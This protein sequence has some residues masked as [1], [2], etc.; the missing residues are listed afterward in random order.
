MK[1][2]DI[3]TSATIGALFRGPSKTRW[4]DKAPS[5][6]DKKP[7]E[8]PVRILR[9]GI[10]GDQQADPRVHGGPER[11]LHHYPVQHYQTWRERFGDL[12]TLR[13]GGVGENLSVDRFDETGVCIGDS[14][15]IGTAII[16]VSQGRV[17]CWKLVRHTGVDDMATAFLDTGHTGWYARVLE[18]G[19]ARV[20]DPIELID[21]T[22]TAWSVARVIR[23][24]LDKKLDREHIEELA[25]LPGLSTHWLESFR[26]RMLA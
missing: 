5:A 16:Q 18:A 6:I 7:V 19:E 22:Q 12:A 4:A 8:G 1:P 10:E 21:R 14:F 2:L 11:A 17:P 20:G 15:R 24:Y 25:T 9:S 13:P 23:A 3:G 26:R